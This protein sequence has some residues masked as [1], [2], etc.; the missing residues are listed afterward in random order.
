MPLSVRITKRLMDILIS[1]L[2]LII[3]SPLLVLIAIAIKLDSPGRVLYTQRRM[4]QYKSFEFGS[5]FNIEEVDTFL[6]FKFRTMY[7]N[8]EARTGAVNAIEN[9]PRVI[10]P[11]FFRYSCAS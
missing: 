8:A 5:P 1:S 6:L 9:D 3:L 10:L 11:S 7:S 2:A 4:K